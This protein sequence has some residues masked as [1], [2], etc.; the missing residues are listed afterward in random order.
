[1]K[2]IRKLV[3]AVLAI[4]FVL[5][6]SGKIT[7]CA[8]EF[9][10][11]QVTRLESAS[12]LKEIPAGF[13]KDV[14]AVV[15][16]KAGVTSECKFT[17]EEDSWVSLTG[18][19]SKNA[20]DG[21]ETHV[22]IY[23]DSAFSR[24]IGEFGWGYWQY[25]NEYTGFLKKGTYYVIVNT[26]QANYDD[27][28]G[29]VN[30]YLGAIPASKVLEPTV[31]YAANKSY[32]TIS[33]PD[34]LGSETLGVQYQKGAISASHNDDKNY[35]KYH[36]YGDTWSFDPKDVVVLSSKDDVYSFKVKANGAYTI[37]ITDQ[38]D[39]RYST[40]VKVTGLDKKKPTVTGVKNKVTYKKAV[41]I[42]F[43]DTESG[44]KSATLNGKKIQSG[45]KVSKAG[46]YKLVVKDKTG[47]TTSLVF[48]VKKK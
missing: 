37:L 18:G 25:D 23:L 48:Y 36:I 40:I 43:Q 7:V 22:D 39:N 17:L 27:F 24:K 11:I 34:V 6:F 13:S 46:T 8:E 26:K 9:E 4:C 20:H 35:W 10:T 14:T 5:A 32:A 38:S 12:G 44:I 1:M 15:G 33:L 2:K 16:D 47:N 41:T 30:L 19:Y 42:R 45:H 29:N 28:V 31:K 3:T 21:G